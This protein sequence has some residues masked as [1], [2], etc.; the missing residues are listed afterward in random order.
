M[1][2]FSHQHPCCQTHAILLFHQ[3]AVHLTLTLVYI[4]DIMPRKAPTKTTRLQCFTCKRYFANI[5]MHQMRSECTAIIPSINQQQRSHDQ[6]HS[7]VLSATNNNLLTWNVVERPQNLHNSSSDHGNDNK[8]NDN[9][10]TVDDNDNNCIQGNIFL[11]DQDLII[12]TLSALRDD[13]LN[14]VAGSNTCL[15]YTSPS[16]RDISG[17]RMPSSA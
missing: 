10:S 6:Q 8:N 13:Q 15:L 9:D 1:N 4:T 14:G 2:H 11:N 16:P 12:T 3:Q 17:S 7:T 5:L